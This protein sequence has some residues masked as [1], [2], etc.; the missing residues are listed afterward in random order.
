MDVNLRVIEF[1]VVQACGVKQG[2]VLLRAL[3][4]AVNEAQ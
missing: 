4:T 1:S 2:S 3:L